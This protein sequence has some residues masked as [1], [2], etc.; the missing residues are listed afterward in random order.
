M[1]YK[2]SEFLIEAGIGG[3]TKSTVDEF[4]EEGRVLLLSR[5]SDLS[6]WHRLSTLAL[7]LEG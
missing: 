6:L 3:P 1:L 5:R 4:G 2:A 7:L